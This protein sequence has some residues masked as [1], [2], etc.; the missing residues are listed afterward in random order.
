MNKKMTGAGW[1]RYWSF[2]ESLLTVRQPK[3]LSIKCKPWLFASWQRELS[4][5]KLLPIWL[6]SSLLPHEHLALDKSPADTRGAPAHRLADQ[7]FIRFSSHIVPCR[8]G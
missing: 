8:L 4:T 6:T 3:M 1:P 5:A 2:P 7:A